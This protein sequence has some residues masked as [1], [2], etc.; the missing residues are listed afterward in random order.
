[1]KF[2]LFLLGIF[3]LIAGPSWGSRVGDSRAKHWYAVIPQGTDTTVL[4]PTTPSPETHFFGRAYQSQ[5]V[6]S[7][8][9]RLGTL[10]SSG[11]EIVKRLTEMGHTHADTDGIWKINIQ[12]FKQIQTKDPTAVAGIVP[13]ALDH[14]ENL[15]M[16]GALQQKTNFE[17]MDMRDPVKAEIK[18]TNY[19]HFTPTDEIALE[20]EVEAMMKMDAKHWNPEQRKFYD[21]AQDQA[22]AAA[23]KWGP[24]K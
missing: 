14:R 13:F 10:D 19:P 24:K 4:L 3:L 21:D 16:M 9:D 6:A 12:R 5:K 18:K 22:M 7:I 2:C 17:K 15:R 20:A 8:G 11:T 1:M 23:K